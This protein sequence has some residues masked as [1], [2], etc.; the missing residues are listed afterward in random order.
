MQLEQ[1]G[2][3]RD[4]LLSE[5]FNHTTIEQALNRGCGCF[6]LF[7]GCL[8]FLHHPWIVKASRRF[9]IHHG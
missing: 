9:R 7:N 1:I 4:G 2:K 3:M 6:Q 5:P 8:D